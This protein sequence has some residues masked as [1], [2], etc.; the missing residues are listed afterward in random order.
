VS[1]AFE[2]DET[3][4]FNQ[5]K[6]LIDEL[7]C[8]QEKHQYVRMI[9]EKVIDNIKSL[10]KIELHENLTNQS[11]NHE[12]FHASIVKNDASLL[13]PSEDDIYHS[14]TDFLEKTKKK[15][16]DLFLIHTKEE[17]IEMMRMKGLES[18]AQRLS[19]RKATRRFTIIRNFYNIKQQSGDNPITLS[20]RADVISNNRNDYDYDEYPNKDDEGWNGDENAEIIKEFMINVNI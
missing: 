15:I 12:N 7:K 18:Y 16:D 9:Y 10:C 19:E 1:L 8:M 6:E 11:Q 17:F 3:K 14:Y 2:D 20:S 5:E 13:T 4:L